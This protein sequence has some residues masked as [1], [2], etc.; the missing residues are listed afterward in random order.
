M[1]PFTCSAVLAVALAGSALAQ[2]TCT[3]SAAL[4]IGGAHDPF[5]A[6]QP[7]GT[8]VYYDTAPALSP[9]LVPMAVRGGDA[10][11][12]VGV[13][14]DINYVAG[15]GGPGPE[16]SFNTTTPS[17]LGIGGYTMPATA[18]LG[19]FLPETTNAGTAPTALDFSTLGSRDF[20]TLSPE[21][22]QIFFIGDGLRNDLAS[23]QEFIAPSGATRLFLGSCDGYGWYDNSGS[24]QFTLEH[25]MA[26]VAQSYC[27]GKL[28]SLGC[29]PAISSSGNAS[30]GGAADFV[31]TC[32]N[33]PE[34]KAGLLFYGFGPQASPFQG[35]TLCVAT[36]TSRTAV[37]VSTGTPPCNATYSI[38]FDLRI[39]SGVDVNLTVGR[40]VYAQWWMRDPQA[41]STTGLSNA[42]S[43]RI[44]P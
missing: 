38:D 26:S 9:Y 11:H 20:A 39:Q 16:G 25:V 31:I 1:Q 23:V 36:P 18:L 30:V 7:D 35:G 43:F 12:F 33:V 41:A 22:F 32:S 27:T 13:S 40:A 5:L 28:D 21:L 17:A 42:L 15:G 14:G 4:S 44:C 19:V 34:N 2:S 8:S 37:Q 6:G 3:E 29:V 10:F 24:C